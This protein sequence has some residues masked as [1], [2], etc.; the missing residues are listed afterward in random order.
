MHNIGVSLPTRIFFN[1]DRK[2]IKHIDE[3][4]GSFNE[5]LLGLKSFGASFVEIRAIEKDDKPDYVYSLFNTLEKAGLD[6]TIHGT[7]G[8]RGKKE[9]VLSPLSEV[10][11]YKRKKPLIVTVH[12]LRDKK[13]PI[14]KAAN[15]TIRSLYEICN[16]SE[17][18]DLPLKICLELNREKGEGDP[19]VTCENVVN[20]VKSVGS[21]RVG[22]CWDFGHYLYN[23]RMTGKE[24]EIP[25]LEFLELVAHTHIHGIHKGITHYPINYDD[26]PMLSEYINALKGVNYSGIY[27]IEMTLRYLLEGKYDLAK[28]YSESIKTIE[29][30]LK[31]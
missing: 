8:S 22:I 5:F 16:Y 3:S 12:A 17:K 1:E 14:V 21:E 7:L 19:S 6:I 2:S 11:A 15:N 4:F 10:L 29:K 27:N 18:M 25:P 13:E 23:C 28:V 24:G 31:D 30:E 20:M 26:M 9:D